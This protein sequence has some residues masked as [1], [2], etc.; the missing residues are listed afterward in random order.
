MTSTNVTKLQQKVDKLELEDVPFL[1][2]DRIKIQPKNNF[3]FIFL[4]DKKDDSQFDKKNQGKSFKYR[5][6]ERTLSW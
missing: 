1:K 5:R 2:K 3:R 4:S 6:V